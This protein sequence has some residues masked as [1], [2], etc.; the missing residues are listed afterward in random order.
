MCL[1]ENPSSGFRYK[2]GIE[3]TG[4]DIPNKGVD[5][6]SRCTLNGKLHG[7]VSELTADGIDFFKDQEGQMS[8]RLEENGTHILN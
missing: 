6:Q 8:A 4:V 1:A 7:A 5:C 3:S 2:P